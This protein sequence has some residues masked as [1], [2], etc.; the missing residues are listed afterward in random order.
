MPDKFSKITP[1]LS[2]SRTPK[3][4]SEN[5]IIDIP[6]IKL[7]LSLILNFLFK[8]SEIPQKDVNDIKK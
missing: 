8:R 2:K 1:S 6:K 5:T 3:I 4:K 7:K